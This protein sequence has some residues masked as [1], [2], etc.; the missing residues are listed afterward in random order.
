MSVL[1]SCRRS[2]PGDRGSRAIPADD[3]HSVPCLL[4]GSWTWGLAVCFVPCLLPSA[5]FRS[6]EG[7]RGARVWKALGVRWFKR[8]ATNG[9]LVNRLARRSDRRYRI[10]RDGGSARAWAE[11]AKGAERNHLV[12]LLMALLTIAHAARIGWYGWAAFLTA[13]NVVFNVYPILL[14]RYN[15]GR[16]ART[17]RGRS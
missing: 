11:E 6:W 3:G 12:F 4:E 1:C 15:R 17:C 7:E 16:I 10:V 9:D 2:V 8:F 14:Q 13:S 5:Y